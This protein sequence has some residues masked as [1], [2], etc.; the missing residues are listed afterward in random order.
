MSLFNNQTFKKKLEYLRA[1]D[2]TKFVNFSI[3]INSNHQLNSEVMNN[4]EASINTIFIQ[5]YIDAEELKAEIKAEKEKEKEELKADKE[6]EKEKIRLEKEAEKEKVRL[7][8]E[9]EK[10][11][12]EEHQR[13]IIHNKLLQQ[14]KEKYK[15]SKIKPVDKQS[16]RMS[17]VI[18]LL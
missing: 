16:K 6:E 8:K 14:E 17:R 18:N 1:D 5:D 15:A 4:I 11:D 10:H 12:K 2:L 7:Q 9:R 13:V 3:T